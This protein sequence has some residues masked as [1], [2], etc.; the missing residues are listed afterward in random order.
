MTDRPTGRPTASTIT[1]N[2][3]DAL[4]ARLDHAEA[5]L[6]ARGEQDS[7]D[8]AAGSYALRAEKAEA[9][10]DRTRA[11][12]R[13]LMRTLDNGCR[14]PT[15]L[16]EAE[17]QALGADVLR[18][19][20]AAPSATEATEQPGLRERHRASRRHLTPEQQTAWLDG[21]DAWCEEQPVDTAPTGTDA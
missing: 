21:L 19:M 1:D 16:P 18:E 5:E 12:L 13:H 8:A 9:A 7:A 17:Q 2:Q 11:A 10:L 15:C 14:W 4:Y 6:L 20:G 3:L